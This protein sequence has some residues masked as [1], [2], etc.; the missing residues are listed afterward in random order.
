MGQP[1]A[2]I[3]LD[4]ELVRK[5]ERNIRRINAAMRVPDALTFNSVLTDKLNRL[6]DELEMDADRVEQQKGR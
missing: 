4:A 5:I 2:T 1:G 6:A 3:V